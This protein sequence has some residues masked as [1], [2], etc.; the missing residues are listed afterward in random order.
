M[1]TIDCEVWIIVNEDGEYVAHEDEEQAG[2]RF[3]DDCTQGIGTRRVK[4][5][6]RVPLPLPILATATVEE[7]EP[8][9]VAS[10]E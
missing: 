6:V 5:T 7:E 2:E 4:V 8:V 10:A 1:K 3:T 9:A